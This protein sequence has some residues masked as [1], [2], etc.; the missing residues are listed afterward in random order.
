[1]TCVSVRFVAVAV[2]AVTVV[3]SVAACSSPGPPRRALPMAPNTA[4]VTINGNDAGGV[5]AVTCSQL[6]WNSTIETF[7]EK[8]GFT[9]IV[10]NGGDKSTPQMVEIRNLGG[11]SGSYWRGLVGQA[12]AKSSNGAYTISGTAEGFFADRPNKQ[13]SGTFK[14]ETVC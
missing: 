5:Q 12:D 11:F 6:Q 2:T 3:A 8:T 7:D 9:A 14:I 10:Q 1:M 4:R 13:T